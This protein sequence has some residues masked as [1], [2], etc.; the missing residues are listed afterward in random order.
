MSAS[1]KLRWRRYVNKLR[2]INE[3]IDLIEE[4]ATKTGSEFQTYLEDYCAK[5]NFNLKALN[6]EHSSKVEQAYK[7]CKSRKPKRKFTWKR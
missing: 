3:E 7:K 2:F 6:K 1:K 5:N 4:I